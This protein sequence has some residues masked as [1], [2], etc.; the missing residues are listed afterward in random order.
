[1]DTSI[2]EVKVFPAYIPNEMRVGA[3]S[4]TASISCVVVEVTTADGITGHG[5]TSIT[6]EEPV[7]AAL[8][9]VVAP[10]ILG[11]DALDRER[12]GEALYW[13]LTPRGQTGYA[14]HAIS[15]VD[16]A[17]WDILGK[18]TGLPC[19]R[20][21]GGA[22][23]TVP[24]YV[25]FGFGAFD[26]DQLGEAARTLRSEGISRFKMVVGH[27]ALARRNQGADVRAILRED[28]ARVRLVREAIG[29]QGELYIDANCSLDDG[30]ARYLA[31]ALAEL[32]VGF[33]E[34]PLR[35]NDPHRM[36]ELRHRTGMRVAAGQNEGQLWR[37]ASLVENDAVDVLQPNAV[38][39]G[40][41]TG[42]AKVAALA[43]ARNIDIANGG[44]F[45]F[46]NSHLHA[47]LANGG[48]V[49]WHLAAVEMCRT[50]FKGLPDKVG[51]TLAAPRRP[52]LGFDLDHDALAEFAGRA[53]S[54][55]HGKG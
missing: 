13:I 53:G 36:R 25:T 15:A 54:R 29:P 10:N 16:L 48:L 1:M 19:W 51:E 12:I 43:G 37:F 11:L 44:A 9:E 6:D 33:F 7:V 49:E 42:A 35:D 31:G 8:T 5:M 27:H 50:L 4:A 55:G 40:G 47:G 21:L 17:L 14:T 22:R 45:P 3:V 26:R 39:C 20:L 38:I 32:G 24:L 18:A 52:G 28:V 46:H 34:E 41:F 2:R 30:S 23:D